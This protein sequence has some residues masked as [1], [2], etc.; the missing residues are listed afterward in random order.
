MDK[1]AFLFFLFITTCSFAQPGGHAHL[2][3]LHWNDF[4]AQNFPFQVTDTISGKEPHTYLVGGTATLLAY[5][6]QI[7]QGSNNVAL[8]NAGDDFQ[9]TPIST[10][11]S[12]RSQIELMN[13]I[14]P[15]AVT[16]GNHEFDYGS[17][18]LRVNLSRA[19]YPV[20][21][22]NIITSG[23]DSTLGLPYI[24]KTFG[25][26]EL[27]IIGLTAPDLESLSL[28]NNLAGLRLRDTDSSLN[29]TL[30]MIR[31][32]YHPNII[33][34]LSH[35][36]FDKDTLLASR[37]NDIDVIVGGHSHTA[38]RSPFK[39]N[40]TIIVQA[41]SRGQYLGK[42]DLDVDV[43]GDSVFNYAGKL[44]ETKNDNIP[45]DPVAERIVNEYE[46]LV[47]SKFGTVIGVLTTPWKR[48]EG[49][50][51]EINIGNFECDAM[52]YAA[53]TDIAFHNVGGIRK[54]LDNGVIK[55]RDIWEINPFGNTLV[56]FSVDGSTL[57]TMMEWQA[58]VAP[59]EFAQ[60][61]GLHYKYDATKPAGKKLLSVE[62]DN[63]P[64]IDT[65]LYSICTNNFI[66]SHLYDFFGLREGSVNVTDT[67]MVDR[68]IIID[69][70]KIK[71]NISSVIEGRIIDV[72]SQK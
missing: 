2:T 41:G 28:K 30:R 5:I 26:V 3:I 57:R 33:V 24:V 53:K 34:L 6:N 68:D 8:L 47:E 7:K 16:L 55:I 62:V 71:K 17:D 35:M 50:K 40:R 13:L 69:Y 12:G 66:G 43:K 49:K 14:N 4:H 58:G 61:G 21:C 70:I 25:D 23:Y 44:I 32:H 46:T 67:G 11:T 42:L 52:R 29:I 1:K 18:S 22:D 65:A 31:T 20:I 59:R 72:S 63:R 19:H 60:V 39:K 56:T 9:G 64:C 48:Q 38:L 27:G 45:P 36:G 54:D 37:R 15:D 10:L 51:T